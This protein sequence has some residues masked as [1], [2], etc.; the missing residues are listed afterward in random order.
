MKNNLFENLKTLRAIA[1]SEEYANKSRYL[2]LHAP[3][4]KTQYDFA[5]LMKA[6]A[7]VTFAFVIMLGGLF[8]GRAAHERVMVAQA[9]EANAKIQI[10]LNDIKYLLRDSAGVPGEKVVRSAELLGQAADK[11]QDASA[12]LSSGNVSESLK[13]INAAQKLLVEI[14]NEVNK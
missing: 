6:G 9:N 3:Q 11:L 12:Y 1:P 14:E 4:E 8:V 5:F 10:R 13:N 2:I 7:A